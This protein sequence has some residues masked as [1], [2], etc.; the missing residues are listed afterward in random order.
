MS[1][2]TAGTQMKHLRL[3]EEGMR[4]YNM[5]R[6]DWGLVGLFSALVVVLSI[7]GLYLWAWVHVNNDLHVRWCAYCTKELIKLDPELTS[8]EAAEQCELYWDLRKFAQN[9]QLNNNMAT[10]MAIGMAAGMAAGR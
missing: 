2:A 9:E 6:I 8:E 5:R 3:T 4:F 7:F 10:G 1:S